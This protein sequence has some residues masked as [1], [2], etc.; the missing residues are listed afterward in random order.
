[1][2]AIVYEAF[3]AS[4]AADPTSFDEICELCASSPKKVCA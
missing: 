4:L 3:R 2:A 1:V